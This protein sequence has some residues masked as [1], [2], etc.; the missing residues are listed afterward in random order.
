MVLCLETCVCLAL[1]Y[2]SNVLKTTLAFHT[3]ETPSLCSDSCYRARHKLPQKD[4]EESSPVL[5]CRL[6]SAVF[7]LDTKE[8]EQSW[9]LGHTL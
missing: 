3:E 5:E 2:Q 1:V 8:T 6:G 7:F 4:V 9:H